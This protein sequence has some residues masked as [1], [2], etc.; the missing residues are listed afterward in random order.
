MVFQELIVNRLAPREAF[1]DPVPE[2]DAFFAQ[3]PAQTHLAPL[4][5]REE[6][7]QANVQILDEDA[8]LFEL[9]KDLPQSASAGI[10][11]G[12]RRQ[13]RPGVYTRAARHADALHSGI[14]F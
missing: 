2:S 9:L 3:L 4:I 12:A 10:P 6:I 7:D 13:D 14:Q 1:V 11:A 8:H 5:A